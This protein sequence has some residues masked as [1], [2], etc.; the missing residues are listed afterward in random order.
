MNAEDVGEV[1][2]QLRRRVPELKQWAIARM[3][4]VHQSTI[5][6][7]ERGRPLDRNLA[8]TA[9]KGLGAR[10]HTQVPSLPD[11]LQHEPVT[12][13]EHANLEQERTQVRDLLAHAA[14]V[15]V[16]AGDIDPCTWV[17]PLTAFAPGSSPHRITTADV[18]Q[19][20]AVT[21]ALRAADYQFGAGACL[22]AITGHLHHA[23][24]LLVAEM[25]A[26]V[27]RQL[28][29][30]L[31]DL[32]NLAGWTS[33]DAGQYHAARGY[34]SRALEQ[35]QHIGE[36]SLVANILYRMGRLHL[37][38]DMPAEA[39][40]FLQ[41]GQIAAQDSGCQLT[42][43]LLCANEGWAYAVVGDVARSRQSLRRAEDEFARAD[44]ARAPAW[45]GFFQEAD[46]DALTGVACAAL[47]STTATYDEAATR[48]RRAVSVRGQQMSRSQAF[49][50]TALATAHIM[51]GDPDEGAKVAQQAIH[52]ATTLRSTRVVDRLESLQR[53]AQTRRSNSDLAEVATA[54]AR[55]RSP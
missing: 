54:I 14:Q 31:A 29:R 5:S 35:A 11:S 4:G 24:Q 25:S 9:L 50:L 21:Q 48:L 47:P 33:F 19:I 1:I 2:R 43:A 38:R 13:V 15:T 41:L 40:R 12:T 30:A 7:V 52:A 8:H 32:H 45:I 28:Y 10:E 44:P 6:R 55:L 22:D 42:V 34:F 3:C 26:P 53:A 16:G 51:G 36:P 37:H 39:L 18:Q 20:E 23:Q 49:E 17:A 27:S 46:L